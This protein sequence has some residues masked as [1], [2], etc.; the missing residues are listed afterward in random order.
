M[1]SKAWSDLKELTLKLVGAVCA[2][3]DLVA[4]VVEWNASPV[5]TTKVLIGTLVNRK[6]VN[7]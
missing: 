6:L 7:A 1:A 2:V 5:R 3:V 4:P